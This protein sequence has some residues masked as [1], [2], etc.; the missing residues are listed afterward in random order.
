MKDWEDPG[1]HDE[2]GVGAPGGGE[3]RKREGDDGAYEEQ[4]VENREHDQN[5]TKGI[6]RENFCHCSS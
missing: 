3:G 1:E 5:F 2:V 4:R 6:L